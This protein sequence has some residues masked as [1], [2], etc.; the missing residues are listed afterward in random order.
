MYSLGY[1]SITEIKNVSTSTAMAGS[2]KYRLIGSNL[3]EKKQYKAVQEI[4]GNVYKRYLAAL[5]T[6]EIWNIPYSPTM[7]AQMGYNGEKKARD[8]TQYRDVADILRRKNTFRKNTYNLNKSKVRKKLTALCR[9]ERSKKFIAF[10]SISFPMKAPDE[11]LYKIYNK[12]LT[13]CRTRYGLKSYAWVAERQDN[14]TLH[15]HLL[16][17]DWMNVQDVNKC[18]ASSID[19]EVRKGTLSWNNSSKEKYNGIDVDSPQYPKKRQG[20]NR[21]QY[22]IRKKKSKKGSIYARMKWIAYYLVKYVTKCDEEFTHLAYHSSRDVSALFTSQLYNEKD[23]EEVL[24]SMSDNLEDYV[25]YQHDRATTYIFKIDVPNSLYEDID[26][27][28]EV[29]YQ[30]LNPE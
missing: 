7:L 4:E 29:V 17:P 1:N 14:G 2:S 8:I 3:I 22:R 21:E 23:A 9:L 16:T 5:K 18:M 19:T 15:F 20:E 11:I 26:K 27:I 30:N 24:Q 28:N 25:I 12:W 6:C 13:S 10:Y